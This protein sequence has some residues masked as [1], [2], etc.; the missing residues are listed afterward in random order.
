MWER[1][2]AFRM[3]PYLASKGVGSRVLVVPWAQSLLRRQKA[4][5]TDSKE[6]PDVEISYHLKVPLCGGEETLRARH[7]CS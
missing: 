6:F 3:T 5:L 7:R 2:Y 4:S 1:H